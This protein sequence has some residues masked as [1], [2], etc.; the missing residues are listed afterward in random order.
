MFYFIL[1]WYLEHNLG[2]K[3]LLE[4][5]RPGLLSPLGQFYLSL[6]IR[7]I[8]IVSPQR[9]LCSRLLT[10]LHPMLRYLTDLPIRHSSLLPCGQRVAN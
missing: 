7:I 10:I 2:L 8:L 4:C 6:Y 5:L 3:H 1:F 9:S